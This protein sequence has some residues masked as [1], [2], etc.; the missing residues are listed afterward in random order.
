[1]AVSAEI[2]AKYE[3]RVPE[4]LARESPRANVSGALAWIRAK[5]LWAEPSPLGKQRS[6]DLKDERFLGAALAVGAKAIVSYDRDLLVL[7]QP[8]GI[9]IMRPSAFLLWMQE[10]S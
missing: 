8:F 2:L 10:N 3:T 6:R 5:A 1:L 7:E 4:V 9:P